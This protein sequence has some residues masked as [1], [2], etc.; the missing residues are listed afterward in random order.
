MAKDR[1]YIH[2]WWYVF[3]LFPPPPTRQAYPILPY[4]YSEERKAETDK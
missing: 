4:I 2:D 3:V 1:I